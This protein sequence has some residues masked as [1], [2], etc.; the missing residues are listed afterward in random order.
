MGRKNPEVPFP[1]SFVLSV[2]HQSSAKLFF[3]VSRRAVQ[4]GGI[5]KALNSPS[6]MST[7]NLQQRLEHSL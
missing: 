2:F 1:I 4:N 6:L 7:P 5:D 3:V